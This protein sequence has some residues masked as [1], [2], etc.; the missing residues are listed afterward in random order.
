MHFAGMKFL[1]ILYILLSL[2]SWA[3]EFPA[4]WW[5]PIPRESSA[6]WEVL[7]Q[8]AKEGEVI[9][10]KRTELGIFSNFGATPFTLD[11][12]FFGSIEGLWQSL[13]Y[14]DPS[15][16]EDLRH[17]IDGWKYSRQEVALMVGREAKQAGNEAN[18]IYRTYKLTQ[19]NW[20][21]QFFD[22]VDHASGSE[23]HYKLIKRAIKAKLDQ[24]PGL[25]D[26]LLQTKC[27]KLRS[28][29]LAGPN[30]PPS[31]RYF[32]ILMVLR[33]ERQGHFCKI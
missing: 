6:S 26:L 27:L 22:Y 19:I 31:F 24:N 10:S 33:E 25:W 21:G 1:G 14:P 30:E 17:R 18:A 28:D 7:P 4:S 5:E 23:Y 13:K 11:G 8:D 9:L 20:L 32:E 16:K 29:H 2:P 12:L 3:H 15:I